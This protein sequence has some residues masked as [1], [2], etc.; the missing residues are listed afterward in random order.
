VRNVERQTTTN[1]RTTWFR[2]E[3]NAWDH[4][5]AN[6]PPLVADLVVMV[7][8]DALGRLNHRKTNYECLLMRPSMPSPTRW[9]MVNILYPPSAASKVV[10][11]KAPVA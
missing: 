7:V 3:R 1:Q 4:G 9:R 10:Y 2:R 8:N 5:T 6:E 11:C